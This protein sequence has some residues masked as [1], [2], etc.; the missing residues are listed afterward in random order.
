M[1]TKILLC[2][3][4]FQYIRGIIQYN[5]SKIILFHYCNAYD[6]F[7]KK[8]TYL[9][10][11]YNIRRANRSGNKFLFRWRMKGWEE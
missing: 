10:S 4:Y 6:R 7:V 11:P 1:H 9:V 8:N 5:H 2:D 3:H